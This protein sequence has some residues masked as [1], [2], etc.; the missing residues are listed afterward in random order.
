MKDVDP[1]LFNGFS[2][3]QAMANRKKEIDEMNLDPQAK[4][5]LLSTVA[6][7]VSGTANH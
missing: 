4:Q 7:K 2:D 5:R 3:L 6:A 1:L